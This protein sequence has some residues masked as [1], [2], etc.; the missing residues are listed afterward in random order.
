[1]EFKLYYEG[2][3]KANGSALD[4]HRL[5][6][7]F[8]QQLKQLWNYQP[9]KERLDW[10]AKTPSKN[11]LSFSAVKTIGGIDVASLVCSQMHMFAELDIILLRK[12]IVGGYGDIDNVLKTLLDGLRC[13][14]ELQEIPT[15]WSPSDDE[16]PLISL[17]EDDILVNRIN[18]HVDRLLK[19]LLADELFILITVR[20]KGATAVIGNL[21]LIV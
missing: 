13:P 12:D 4:K 7:Y 6:Q 16:Q 8:H 1:M 11:R 2:R 15:G 5:R 14:K 18:I 21:D 3:I 9:L 17:L 19:P 20:V 10:I